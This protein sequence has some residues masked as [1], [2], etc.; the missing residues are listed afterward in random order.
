MA[1]NYPDTPGPRLAYDRDGTQLFRVAANGTGSPTSTTQQ[2]LIDTNKESGNGTGNF[3][4]DYACLIFPEPRDLVGIW[5]VGTNGGPSA[6]NMTSQVSTDTTNGVDGTWVNW[7]SFTVAAN[8]KPS[9]RTHIATGA[10][11]GVIA[12]RVKQVGLSNQGKIIH[13]YGT[14][15]AAASDRLELWH[16]TLNQSL[17][18]TPAYLDWGNRPRDTTATRQFRIKN[19]SSALVANS[20]TVGM[21]SLSDA[22]P[23]Y[24]SQHQFAYNGGAFASTATISALAPGEISA[25]IDV[26][27]TLINTASLGLWAQRVYAATGEWV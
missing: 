2:Q 6:T 21:E 20:I 16:P 13:L 25:I 9:F 1:G 24:V 26:R 11:N 22:S 17:N 12:I 19:L 15:S 4:D 8:Y 3:G 10:A 23:T 7:L 18:I 5:A 27:Q 14:P